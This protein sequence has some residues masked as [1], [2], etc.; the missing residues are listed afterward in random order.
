[1]RILIGIILSISIFGACENQERE[2]KVETLR[3]D[4][5]SDLIRNPIQSD[6]TID[7]SQLARIAFD[8]SSY[9]FGVISQ[10]DSVRHVFTF[11]NP[12]KVPLLISD[13]KSTCGCTVPDWPSKVI[14]TGEKGEIEVLFDSSEREGRQNKQITITANTIPN[15][16]K[17]YLRG[18]V[19]TEQNQQ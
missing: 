16:T 19:Q 11:T 18:Y 4:K 12:G 17:L 5:P 14:K 1:M 2:E 10:G 13:A 8:H 6:G 7:S 9:D 15:Q 3:S